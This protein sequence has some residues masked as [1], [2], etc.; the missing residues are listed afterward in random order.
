[1]VRDSWPQLLRPRP[2]PPRGPLHAGPRGTVEDAGLKMNVDPVER[3]RRTQV[4]LNFTSDSAGGLDMELSS[5]AY[6]QHPDNQIQLRGNNL[7][8]KVEG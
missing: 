1:M 7:Q 6:P 5:P 3:K 2:F 8:I 4:M